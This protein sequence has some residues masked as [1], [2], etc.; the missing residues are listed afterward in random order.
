MSRDCRAREAEPSIRCFDEQKFDLRFSSKFDSR[1]ELL[2]GL[3]REWQ[4]RNKGARATQDKR[5]QVVLK[6][7]RSV[8]QSNSTRSCATQ[9]AP[10]LLFARAKFAR[11]SCIPNCGIAT[12]KALFVERFSCD[13]FLLEW[14]LQ[15]ATTEKQFFFLLFSIA[16]KIVASKENKKLF[17]FHLLRFA[18]KTKPRKMLRLES[19]KVAFLQR[20]KPGFTSSAFCSCFCLNKV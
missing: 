9:S 11:V 3:A 20:Q 1:S 2:F 17:L 13:A 19:A 8:N 14:N 12:R 7:A 6:V 10:R 15:N 5:R 16:C 4:L 18:T